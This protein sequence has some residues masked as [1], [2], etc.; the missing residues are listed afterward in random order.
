[1]PG[2]ASTGTAECN[3]I[4]VEYLD[5]TAPIRICVWPQSDVRSR[6]RG[7]LHLVKVY[8]GDLSRACLDGLPPVTHLTAGGGSNDE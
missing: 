6:R 5:G 2:V 1:M 3:G 8:A 4:I 7:S